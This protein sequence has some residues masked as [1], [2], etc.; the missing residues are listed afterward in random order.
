MDALLYLVPGLI[1]AGCVSGAVQVI[2]HTLRTDRAWTHGL[3]AEGRCLN[4]YTKTNGSRD[5]AARRTLH[6][7][8]EFTTREGE[9]V[10]FDEIGGDSTVVPGDHV[11]VRYPAERPQWATALPPA[12]GRLI[13]GSAV[14]V[15]FM[16]AVTVGCVLFAVSAHSAV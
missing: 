11:V 12:R 6:H 13:L 10:R 5:T 15:A 4:T 8:Y 16:G 1:I 7:V 3:T 9:R 14:L 2:R